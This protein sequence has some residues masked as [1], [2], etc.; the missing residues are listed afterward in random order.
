MIYSYWRYLYPSTYGGNQVEISVK[1][2]PE[3]FYTITIFSFSQLP[4]FDFFTSVTRVS[5][6]L[7]FSS[8]HLSTQFSRVCL[9]SFAS[10]SIVASLLI[11]LTKETKNNP[12]V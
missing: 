4:G 10:A 2:I 6:F 7:N 3:I 12:R 1:K 11:P 9:G 8:I 5:F